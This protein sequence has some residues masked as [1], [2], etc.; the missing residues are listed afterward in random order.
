MSLILVMICLITNIDHVE[1][2]VP[3]VGKGTRFAFQI[4]VGSVTRVFGLLALC[5]IAFLVYKCVVNREGSS[6]SPPPMHRPSATDR[7]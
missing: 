3:G 5:V 1:E 2:P 6:S 7:I 4:S